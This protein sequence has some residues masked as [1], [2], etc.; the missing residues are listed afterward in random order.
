MIGRDD[1]ACAFALIWIMAGHM[2][3]I[4]DMRRRNIGRQ[5]N[6]L[7][8]TVSNHKVAPYDSQQV[9]WLLIG[10]ASYVHATSLVAIVDPETETGIP[11]RIAPD[12]VPPALRE[13]MAD[14]RADMPEVATIHTPQRPSH[15]AEPNGEFNSPTMLF[16]DQGDLRGG[17]RIAKTDSWASESPFPDS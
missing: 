17:S 9:S 3:T 4:Q 7:D 1:E 10:T 13:A 14:S 2:A 12:D 16:Y 8:I 11:D 15:D 6:F 5:G